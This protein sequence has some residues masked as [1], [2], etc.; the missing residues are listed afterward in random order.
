MNT[1]KVKPG[2]RVYVITSP[3]HTLLVKYVQ[4]NTSLPKQYKML[5]IGA[6]LPE[7][8]GQT[9]RDP[10]STLCSTLTDKLDDF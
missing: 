4:I 8:R 1:V 2:R 10:G 6:V 3:P 7:S 9:C 5:L